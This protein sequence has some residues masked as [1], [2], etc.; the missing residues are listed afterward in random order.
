VETVAEL[1]EFLVHLRKEQYERID[2]AE[3]RTV[4]VEARDRVLPQMDRTLSRA[5]VRRMKKMGVDVMLNTTVAGF[6]GSALQFVNGREPLPVDTLVWAAGVRANPVLDD[7]ALQKD[8]LG[9]VIV[10][11]VLR[12]PNLPNVY[13][14]GDAAHAVHPQT[15]EVYPPT[16]QVVDRTAS[17]TSPTS[18]IWFRW[19]VWPAWLTRSE[20]G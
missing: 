18:V 5:S 20:S 17:S 12:V 4:L 11:S 1:R 2:P 10:D 16:A 14:L 19:G 13:V 15:G 8:R 6:S 9:R 7:L 3:V